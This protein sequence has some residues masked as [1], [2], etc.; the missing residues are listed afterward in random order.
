MFYNPAG[1][2]GVGQCLAVEAPC[3][4]QGF[5]FLVDLTSIFCGHSSDIPGV[6]RKKGNES[7]GG[8]NEDAIE[9]PIVLKRFTSHHACFYTIVR[10]LA[11]CCSE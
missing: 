10:C 5:A 1:G 2:D 8:A 6:R 7:N 4:K 11:H 9:P 3:S